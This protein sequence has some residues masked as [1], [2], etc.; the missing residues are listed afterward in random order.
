MPMTAR[1]DRSP[2]NGQDML[3]QFQTSSSSRSTSRRRPA[4][5]SLCT[6]KKPE[7]EMIVMPGI[8]PNVALA[9]YYADPCQTPSFTQSLA[10]IVLDQSALHARNEHPRLRPAELEDKPEGY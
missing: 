4:S 8:Y 10:K 2:Q 9:E 6:Q 3:G 7:T 5:R 1:K